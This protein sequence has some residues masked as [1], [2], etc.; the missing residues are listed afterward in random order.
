MLG[1]G[2]VRFWQDQANM[3]SSFQAEFSAT[4]DTT[5][6]GQIGVAAL[7]IAS[8]SDTVSDYLRPARDYLLSAK[9]A[10]WIKCGVSLFWKYGDKFGSSADL[11]SFASNAS[12]DIR[13]AVAKVLVKYSDATVNQTLLRLVVDKDTG[14][15]AAALASITVVPF[16]VGNF[17][18]SA[19][20]DATNVD[21][22]V[23][24]ASALQYVKGMGADQALLRLNADYYNSVSGP[25]LTSIAARPFDA[26]TF[27]V[28][29]LIVVNIFSRLNLAKALKYVMGQTV[30]D[31]LI[32]LS[33]DT[34]ADIQAAAKDSL[35]AH[36]VGS[37]L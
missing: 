14:V 20:I 31:A 16:D 22:R 12:A 34:N 23:S 19:L 8:D 28:S 10:L 26:G 37:S 15:R 27:N 30:V 6:Q 2:A 25:A 21:A 24:L 4:T 11:E 36:G 29:S 7:S 33:S 35:K 17:N 1:V 3:M 18:V 32:T 9:D 13:A 5:Y